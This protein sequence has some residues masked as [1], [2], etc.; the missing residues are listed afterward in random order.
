MG[1]LDRDVFDGSILSVID[2]ER[3]QYLNKDVL[4][5]EYEV[6]DESKPGTVKK[7]MGINIVPKDG[8]VNTVK[9]QFRGVYKKE[10]GGINS[11]RLGYLSGDVVGLIFKEVPD[12]RLKNFSTR[13]LKNIDKATLSERSD[14]L[15]KEA[16][17]EL[18]RG[19]KLDSDKLKNDVKRTGEEDKFYN[20]YS[21]VG[22]DSGIVKGT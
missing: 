18:F 7:E 19:N 22:N 15:N 16:Q 12:D 14:L 11:D 20:A 9:E 5:R 1:E 21:G 3:V 10:I 17:M 8:L 2:P 13:Q 6:D 4:F